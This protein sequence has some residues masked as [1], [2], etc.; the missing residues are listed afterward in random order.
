MPSNRT[1]IGEFT[2]TAAAAWVVQHP[3]RWM[4]PFLSL[5]L[6]FAIAVML[7]FCS[8][9]GR[10]PP[11]L[12]AQPDLPL[13]Y[14]QCFSLA[15]SLAAG[16]ASSTECPSQF[17]KREK[18]QCQKTENERESERDRTHE[19]NMQPCVFF[20]KQSFFLTR[21]GNLANLLLKAFHQSRNKGKKRRL[22]LSLEKW[23]KKITEA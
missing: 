5:S 23:Q 18:C 3:P 14:H 4:A 7:F 13:I 11:S 10:A 17:T 19:A 1:A 6:A 16:T 22:R 20:C 2:H 9:V 12:C 15:R 8:L 21:V